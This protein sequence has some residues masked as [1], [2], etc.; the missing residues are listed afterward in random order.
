M[1]SKLLPSLN[2]IVLGTAGAAEHIHAAIKGVNLLNLGLLLL[3]LLLL[4]A[5]SRGSSRSG[6]GSDGTSSARV[7]DALDVRL[8]E[9]SEQGRPV[10]GGG[11]AR[12]SDMGQDV[13]GG[14]LD[15]TV[16]EAERGEGAHEFVFLGSSNS[17]NWK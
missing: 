7:D 13:V 16:V 1:P 3:L 17:R 14:D 15:I 4:T 6:R 11:V 12:G 2:L 5:G 9:G 10:G 8:Q